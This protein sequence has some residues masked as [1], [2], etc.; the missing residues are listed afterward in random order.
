M[1]WAHIWFRG[2]LFAETLVVWCLSVRANRGGCRY[3]GHA[4]ARFWRPEM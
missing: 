1:N 4:T 3:A 2:D